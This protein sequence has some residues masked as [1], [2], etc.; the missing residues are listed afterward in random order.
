MIE[1]MVTAT[2]Q[3]IGALLRGR[4]ADGAAD[5]ECGLPGR[6]R[7]YA[8]SPSWRSRRSRRA[9]STGRRRANG[10]ISPRSRF[11]KYFLR[12]IRRGESEPFYE[13]FL[14]DK[15]NIAKIKEVENGDMSARTKGRLRQ[16]RKDQPAARR[17]GAGGGAL[18]ILPSA[19]LQRSSDRGRRG[20]LRPPRGEQRYPGAD[21]RLGAVVRSVPRDGADVRACRAASSNPN[22]RLLKLNSDNAPG[23][24]LAPQHQR[25]PHASVDARW[26]RDCPHL[27]RDGRA[28]NCRLDEGRARPAVISFKP[29]GARYERR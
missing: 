27:R 8:A 18:R 16:L 12:K 28:A 24:L 20:R 21:R 10:C 25:H 26:P 2:A 23:A 7:R 29:K 14:L 3:N 4:G 17:T 22:V 19:D 1:S 6:F 15:L 13:R 11:E 9:T 5:L